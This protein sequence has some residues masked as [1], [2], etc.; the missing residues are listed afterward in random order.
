MDRPGSIAAAVISVLVVVGVLVIPLGSLA[1]TDRGV[2]SKSATGPLGGV[3][4]VRLLSRCCG[5]GARR[6]LCLLHR[7]ADARE[8]ENF[9]GITNM[10]TVGVWRNDGIRSARVR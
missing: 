1:K 4:L 9:V 2:G 7:R 5:L 6:L 10:D 3:G 8:Y